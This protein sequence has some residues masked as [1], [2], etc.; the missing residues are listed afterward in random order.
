MHFYCLIYLLQAI[1][2]PGI[3]GTAHRHQ[4]PPYPENISGM[5][6]GRQSF[7]CGKGI[8]RDTDEQMTSLTKK[9]HKKGANADK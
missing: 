2:K 1:P 4:Y 5:G 7:P 9:V 8:S 3:Y 6:Q